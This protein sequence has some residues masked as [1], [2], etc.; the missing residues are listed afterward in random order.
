MIYTLTFQPSIDYVVYV[1]QMALNKMNRS[2]RER[3]VF[4]GKGLNVSQVLHNLGIESIALGFSAGFTGAEIERG[5]QASGCKTDFVHLDRG[6]SRINVKIKSMREGAV[7]EETEVNGLGPELGHAAIEEMLHKLEALSPEDVMILAGTVPPSLAFDEYRSVLEK[8][9]AAG[10]GL[11]VDTTGKHLQETL[12]YHPLLIKPNQE[13][14]GDIFDIKIASRENAVLYAGKLQRMGASNV[15]VSFAGEGAILV[16]EQ[17]Y[18]L[19]RDA[20]SGMVVNSVGAGD[21]MVAGFVAGYLRECGG[22]KTAAGI[23]DVRLSEEAYERVLH[24]AVSAG[25]ATAFSEGLASGE[26]IQAMLEQ[27]RV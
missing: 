14:L 22:D 7:I 20:C 2:K 16:T 25:S 5:M 13:E 3:V 19:Q 24:L 17:G 4:G 1:E 12:Q 9:H 23:R 11:V 18:I 15:L 6:D 27:K 21:S 8:I 26:V 10:A